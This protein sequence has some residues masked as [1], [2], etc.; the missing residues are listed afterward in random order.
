MKA[1]ERDQDIGWL[2]LL[3]LEILVWQMCRPIAADMKT[4]GLHIAVEGDGGNLR[5]LLHINILFCNLG[6]TLFNSIA[7]V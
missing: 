5:L 1:V 6:L 7:Y 4:F 3:A 2:K